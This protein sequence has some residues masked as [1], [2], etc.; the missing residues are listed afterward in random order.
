MLILRYDS[1]EIVPGG[2]GNA[3]NN[4]AALGARVDVVGV[5]GRRLAGRRLLDALARG[6][7]CRA[8]SARRRASR[9]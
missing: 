4:A 9:R 3:A 8:S 6:R 5:V 7:D 2:A 1:T